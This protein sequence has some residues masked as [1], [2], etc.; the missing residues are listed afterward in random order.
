MNPI[1]SCEINYVIGL[2][3]IKFYGAM[4]ISELIGDVQ[5]S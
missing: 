4:G 5:E 2:L 1:Q 3:S